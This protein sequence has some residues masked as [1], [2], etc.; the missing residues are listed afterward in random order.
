VKNAS[1]KPY[2]PSPGVGLQRRGFRRPAHPVAGARKRSDWS[3][4]SG[5]AIARRGKNPSSIGYVLTWPAGCLYSP[6]QP[7]S[8][9][10]HDL[11]CN[12]LGLMQLEDQK[13]KNRKQQKEI[14][15]SQGKAR[16]RILADH[17]RRCRRASARVWTSLTPP[18]TRLEEVERTSIFK[19]D[20]LYFNKQGGTKEFSHPL[21]LI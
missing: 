16:R 14:A 9:R 10:D 2:S 5:G 12:R 6:V 7:I 11:I 13:I 21:L 15:L 3:S 4:Y 18:H 8:C 19:Y 17:S 1:Q 20:Y